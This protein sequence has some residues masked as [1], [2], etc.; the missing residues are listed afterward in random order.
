MPKGS[1]ADVARA[2]LRFGYGYLI[3]R[4]E[5]YSL[6]CAVLALAR[7]ELCALPAGC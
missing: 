2:M 3:G 1:N 6:G 4:V 7:L 5:T